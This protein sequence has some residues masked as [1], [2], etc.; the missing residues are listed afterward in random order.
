MKSGIVRLNEF[1]VKNVTAVQYNCSFPER[2]IFRINITLLK[3]FLERPKFRGRERQ[4]WLAK[5]AQAI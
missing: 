3:N 1:K 2:I 5:P 4:M